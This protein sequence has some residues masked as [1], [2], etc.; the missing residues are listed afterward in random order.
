VGGEGVDKLMDIGQ[1]VRRLN[2]GDKIRRESWKDVERFIEPDMD[3]ETDLKLTFEDLLATDW[4]M[5]DG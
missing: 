5:Y 4:E 3:E 1:A 2:N